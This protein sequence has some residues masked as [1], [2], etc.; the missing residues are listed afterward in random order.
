[1]LEGKKGIEEVFM[2]LS[3]QLDALSSGLIEMVVC[4]GAALNILGYVQRTTEDVDVIAFVN[5]NKQGKNVLVK[6]SPMKSALLEAARRVQRDFDLK[7][8]WLNAGPSSVM[9]LSLPDGL[10]DRVETR[11]YGKNLIIHLLGRYDQIHF[12]L[13]AAVDQGGKHV[14][15]LMA[16]RP[17]AGELEKAAH[18]SMTHDPSNGYKTVLKSFLEQIGYKDVADKL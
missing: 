6:A 15:D 14:D 4:G 17:T 12:K 16:L 7:E 9:D 3:E 8:N 18:W 11:T 10:M 5:K 2:A 1:M 13:Y